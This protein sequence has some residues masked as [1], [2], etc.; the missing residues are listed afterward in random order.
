MKIWDSVY[1]YIHCCIYN[2][3]K[4]KRW[5]NYT[6]WS[7]LK[8]VR[9]ILTCVIIKS[10]QHQ[11]CY[12][13]HSLSVAT[14]VIL[15]LYPQKTS[16]IFF[17]CWTGSAIALFYVNFMT[18]QFQYEGLLMKL[19]QSQLKRADFTHPPVA[20]KFIQFILSLYHCQPCIRPIYMAMYTED[21]NDNQY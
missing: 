14:C 13:I 18:P 19:S 6:W 7:N 16:R 15:L 3:E 4:L 20:S 10:C 2:P 5:I 21:N 9:L 17:A 12:S 1:T 8:V 11:I